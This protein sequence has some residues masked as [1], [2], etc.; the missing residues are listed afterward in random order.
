VK[1]DIKLYLILANA[2]LAAS[3]ACA[4][5]THAI[6]C[7]CVGATFFV[8]GIRDAEREAKEPVAPKETR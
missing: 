7:I 4:N 6:I 3:L 2:W 8:F 1:G 5:F